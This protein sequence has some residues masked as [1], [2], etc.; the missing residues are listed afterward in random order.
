MGS[1]VSLLAFNEFKWVRWCFCLPSKN[2]KLLVILALKEF[3]VVVILAFHD[4]GSGYSCLPLLWVAIIVSG[5][6][7]VQPT[8]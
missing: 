2:F 5:C 6:S 3:D 1:V 4:V 7:I 8:V